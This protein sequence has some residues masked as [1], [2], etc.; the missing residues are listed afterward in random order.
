VVINQTKI[1]SRRSHARTFFRAMKT[2]FCTYP[3]M[4]SLVLITFLTA[5]RTDIRAQLAN[6]IGMLTFKTH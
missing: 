3:A 1:R 2:N 5:G 6:S 4:V